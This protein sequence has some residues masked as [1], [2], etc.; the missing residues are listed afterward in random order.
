MHSP[1]GREIEDG[2]VGGSTI[3]EPLIPHFLL[4]QNR[5]T[6]PNPSALQILLFFSHILKDC[7]LRVTIPLSSYSSTVIDPVTEGLT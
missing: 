6:K 2:A 5:E 7:K 1:E 3:L 4:L